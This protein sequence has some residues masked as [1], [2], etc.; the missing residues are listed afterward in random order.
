MRRFL[1]IAHAD[2]NRIMLGSVPG[3]GLVFCQ[4]QGVGD[5]VPPKIVWQEG[6]RL[7]WR[8][9]WWLAGRV[10]RLVLGRA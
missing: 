7:G 8:F 9:R 6:Q 5:K 2:M 10:L 4:V 3:K 1:H